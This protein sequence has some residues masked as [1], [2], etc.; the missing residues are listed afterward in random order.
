M[1]KS[2]FA[3][4]LVLILVIFAAAA[5]AQKARFVG[6]FVTEDPDTRGITRLTLFD[7]DTVN[8]W[9]RCHPTDCDWGP[10][11]AVAYASSVSDDLRGSVRALSVIYIKGHAVT[12]LIIKPLKDDRL[13]VEVFTRFTDR[14]GRTAYSAKYIMVRENAAP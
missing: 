4:A 8:V 11:T 10:E 9:G 2:A 1:R 7:D 13:S 5:N 6:S 3:S 14:S 12:V